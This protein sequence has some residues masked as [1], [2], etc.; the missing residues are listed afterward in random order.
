M[1]K[2]EEKRKLREDLIN[3]MKN[4]I[5]DRE[6]SKDEQ[7]QKIMAVINSKPLYKVYEEKYKN[8][9]EMPQLEQKKKQLEDL[10]NFYKPL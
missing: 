6:Q 2:D 1:K 7:K 3:K 5:H 8:D 10:R 4:K 9:V